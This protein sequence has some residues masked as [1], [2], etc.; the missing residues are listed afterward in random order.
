MGPRVGVGGPYRTLGSA[1]GQVVAFLVMLDDALE[2]AV[3]HIGIAGPQQ[4][5]GRQD[6]REPAITVSE[7]MDLQEHHDEDRDDQH[8]VERLVAVSRPRSGDQLGH[9]PRGVERCRRGEHDAEACPR[10]L[11]AYIRA[12]TF[13]LPSG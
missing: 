3:G 5:Q 12:P 10:R 2:R 6:A 4:E 1:Q 8:W 7:G 9:A 11:P 13:V